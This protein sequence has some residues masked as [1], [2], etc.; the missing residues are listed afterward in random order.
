MEVDSNIL[1]G[2]NFLRLKKGS[3]IK[4]FDWEDNDLNEFL[5][6]KAIPYRK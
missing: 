4:P 3:H 6:E 2:L 5:F 1:Q